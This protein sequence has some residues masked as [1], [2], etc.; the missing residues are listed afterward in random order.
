[1]LE[2]VVSKYT[3][4]LYKKP[5]SRCICDTEGALHASK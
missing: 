1:M 5:I 2:L 3:S 4:S